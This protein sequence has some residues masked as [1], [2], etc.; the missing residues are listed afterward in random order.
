MLAVPKRLHADRGRLRDAD[1]VG[2][3][4]FAAVREAGRDDVLRDV[5]RG[6][7]GG[8][9]DLRW[10]LAGERAAAM[11][12]HAAVRVDDDLAPGQAAVADRAADDEIAGRVDVKLRLR[13][14]P[15]LRQHLL[16]HELHDRFAQVRVL[17]VRCVLRRQ[18]D[19]VEARPRGRSCS[20]RSPAISHRVAARAAG[21]CVAP[22]P[23]ARP[24][25]ARSRSAPASASRSRCSHSRTS[26][27]G[28]RRPVPRDPCGRRPSRCRA[29]ACQ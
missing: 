4:D 18:H 8:P 13:R 12:R 6:I 14:D 2:D 1:R 11:T 16:D 15:V 22:R 17:D 29:T 24:A 23:G 25:G 26:G 21:R 10:I 3:L 7:R 27:P 28:R 5:A 20:G 9:V 19:R